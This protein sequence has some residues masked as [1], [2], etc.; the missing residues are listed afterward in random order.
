MEW[1]SRDCAVFSDGHRFTYAPFLDA[2]VR[3]LPLNNERR[4]K[5]SVWMNVLIIIEIGIH[6]YCWRKKIHN[7]NEIQNQLGQWMCRRLSRNSTIFTIPEKKRILSVLFYS[8]VPTKAEE[9][10]YSTNS[11]YTILV[12]ACLNTYRQPKLWPQ[13]IM[14]FR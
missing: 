9:H 4:F 11:N 13:W 8:S 7:G 14:S 5:Y 2:F 10:K 6:F 1:L 12:Y 3:Y